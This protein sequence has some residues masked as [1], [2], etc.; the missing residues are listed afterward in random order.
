MIKIETGD[1]RELSKDIADDSIDLILT[2]PVYDRID[3]YRDLSRLAARVLK[4]NTSLLAFYG[5]GYPWLCME[6]LGE[7]LRYRWTLNYYV[8][9]KSVK[10]LGYNLFAHTTP[11]YWYVKGNGV[12]HR[13]IVDTRRMTPR[14]DRLDNSSNH[15]WNKHPEFIAYYLEAFTQPGDLVLDSFCG[16]GTI[17]AVCKMLGRN[18][19]G[20]EIDPETAKAARKRVEETQ[21]PLFALQGEQLALM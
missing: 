19:I 8:A 4:P 13:R 1:F 10:L 16:G 2:D 5:G 9:G 14:H 15:E 11:L 20:H 6:A 12:P 18:C 17:P 21:P 3:D 7:S